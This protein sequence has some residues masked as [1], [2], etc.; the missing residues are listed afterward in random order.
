MEGKTEYGKGYETELV[1]NGH[2]R[3]EKSWNPEE[4]TEHLKEDGEYPEF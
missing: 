4:S 1:N 2:Q 3:S